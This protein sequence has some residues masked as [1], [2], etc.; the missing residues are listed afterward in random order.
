MAKATKKHS[1]GRAGVGFRLIVQILCV[2]FLVVVVNVIGFQYFARGDFSRSQKFALAEQTKQVLRQLQK[3]VRII[4]YFSGGGG[5]LEAALYPDILNLLREYEFSGRDRVEIEVI[6][7]ARDLSRA[8]EL[9]TK[10]E[11]AGDQNVL[12]L[13]YDGDVSVLPVS[14]MGEFDLSGVAMGEPARLVAFAGEQALTGALLALLNPQ[15][16]VVYALDGH[17]EIPTDEQTFLADALVRQNAVLRSFRF[18]PGGSVPDDASVVLIGGPTYDLSGEEV[19][20]LRRFRKADGRLIVALDPEADTP[21]LA[22]FL[23][24]FG[25][26]PEENRVL[27]VFPAPLQPGTY[28]ISKDVPGVFL[29]GSQITKRLEG[30]TGLF[31]VATQSLRPD[32]KAAAKGGVKLRP[33]VGTPEEFWGEANFDAVED[34]VRYDEGVDAGQ[35]FEIAISAERGGTLDERVEVA[36]AKMVVV[37]NREFLR[38]ATIRQA[39]ANLDFI[40]SSV[41]WMVD[42]A[43]LTGITPKVVQRFTLSLTP[44]EIERI[45][46]YVMLVIPGVVAVFG[47]I[48]AW[49]RRA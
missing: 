43:K 5:G 6:N 14:E 22:G 41:N 27:A 37:G 7:P 16:K 42:R 4:V 11:I 33:L 34:G 2:L 44:T 9:Q 31:P 17:G 49:R 40:V 19:N 48:V 10:F 20:A 24:E 36:S 23:S 12:I 32:A 28:G 38:D 26:V 13:D 25:I 29:E 45:G 39:G 47:L 8:R 1:V 18:T 3:D 46:F 15:R 30:A 35:P 21:E